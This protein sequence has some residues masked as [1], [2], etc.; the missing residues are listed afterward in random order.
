MESKRDTWF[1]LGFTGYV[2][3][4]KVDREWEPKPS[5]YE[6]CKYI[7]NLGRQYCVSRYKTEYVNER[8]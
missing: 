5:H 1:K 7:G 6:V 8:Q 3:V 4:C 2:G